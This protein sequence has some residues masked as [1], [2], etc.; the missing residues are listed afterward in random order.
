M[1]NDLLISTF[2]ASSFLY[3]EKFVYL[4]YQSVPKTTSL[5]PQSS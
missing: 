5:K 4:G 2:Q 3:L 1:I